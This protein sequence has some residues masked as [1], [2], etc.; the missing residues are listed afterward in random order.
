MK[1]NYL[2]LLVHRLFDRTKE[3]LSQDVTRINVRHSDGTGEEIIKGKGEVVIYHRGRSGT[4]F[5]RS[6]NKK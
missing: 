6:S 4:V 1:E 2:L 5:G 3:R